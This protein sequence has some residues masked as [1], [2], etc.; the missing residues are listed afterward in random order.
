MKKIILFALVLLMSSCVYS[1]MYHF[2]EGDLEW[3]SPYEIGDMTI[4]ETSKGKDT[5]YIIKKEIYDTKNPFVENEGQLWDDFY[6][7]A[8]YEGKFIHNSTI[9][10]IWMRIYKDSDGSIGAH[11]QMGSRFCFSL[12]ID[13]NKSSKNSLSISDTIFINDDNSH[14]GEHGPFV[15]DFESFKWSKKEG[16]IEYRLRDGTVYP[17]EGDSVIIF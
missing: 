13:N 11:F 10:D 15:N 16:L 3:M 14:Y 4:F 17:R 12:I 7:F 1:H 2:E 9:H 6:A 8:Q 5:L